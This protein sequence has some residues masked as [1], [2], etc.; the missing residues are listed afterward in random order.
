[1]T[2]KLTVIGTIGQTQGMT[3]AP[4]PPSA[5]K[6]RKGINPLWAV[7]LTALKSAMAVGALAAAFGAVSLGAGAGGDA[8]SAVA[9]AG[10]DTAA[11]CGA[12]GVEVGD[13]AAEPPGWTVSTTSGRVHWPGKLQL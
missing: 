1:L 2:K 7:L 8:G 9:V 6:I 5:E 13:T 12:A 10:G 3:N 11:V 4:R